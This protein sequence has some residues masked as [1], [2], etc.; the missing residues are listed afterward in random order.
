[1]GKKIVGRKGMQGES[2]TDGTVYAKVPSEASWF[3]EMAENK[4]VE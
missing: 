2:Q 3:Q 4:T 1:M